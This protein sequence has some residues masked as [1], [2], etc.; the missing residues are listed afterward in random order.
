MSSAAVTLQCPACGGVLLTLQQG[1]D[2]AETCPHCSQS[3]PREL[4]YTIEAQAGPPP[5]VAYAPASAY[6]PPPAPPA[7]V[8][9]PPV[10]AMA[11]PAKLWEAALLQQQAQNTAPAVTGVE[12]VTAGSP[13]S[14]QGTPLP[15]PPPQIGFVPPATS[16]LSPTVFAPQPH[17]QGQAPVVLPLSPLGIANTDAVADSAEPPPLPAPPG[18][19]VHIAPPLPGA[20]PHGHTATSHGPA[21]SSSAASSHT[22]PHHPQELALVAAKMLRNSGPPTVTHHHR[23]RR[24][25]WIA[26]LIFGS[27]AL[28]GG[29]HFL[30]EHWQQTDTR[31]TPEFATSAPSSS[32]TSKPHPLPESKETIPPQQVPAV[33]AEKAAEPTPDPTPEPAP[34]A[35]SINTPSQAPAQT[36]ATTAAREMQEAQTATTEKPEGTPLVPSPEI[37]TIPVPSSPPSPPPPTPA[38][39]APQEEVRRALPSDATT[40]SITKQDSLHVVA[41]KLVFGIDTAT[42]PEERARWIADPQKHSDDMERLVKKHGGR[43]NTREVEP[44]PNLGPVHTLP[45][46]DAVTLFRVNSPASR[47][48]AMVRLHTTANGNHVIDWPLFA[49]TYDNVFDRF[50]A[51]NH[52]SPREGEWFTVLCNLVADPNTKNARKEPHLMLKVQGS[53]AETGVTEA[54]VDKNS[55]AGRY[56]Q[57]EMRHGRT[58]LIDLQVG[59]PDSSTR[60]LMVL[61]CSATRSEPAQM[62]ANE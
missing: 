17:V 16:E 40:L 60:H 39:A 26:G 49:Q 18:L 19:S 31:F 30:K 34:S 22:A 2:G 59:T 4:Y 37:V 27:L 55:R 21:A 43:L 61:D 13:V 45:S 8:P 35:A 5:P 42:T 7:S 46:G 11:S 20:V 10:A 52:V 29:L 54:W 47:G 57:K 58:Y 51:T 62:N 56:L 33:S 1:T 12:P 32:R 23:P 24:A 15:L 9:Q 14:A 38:P 53:L 41:A 3:A 50:I 48:G 25:P 28:A 36:T 44:L 6:T